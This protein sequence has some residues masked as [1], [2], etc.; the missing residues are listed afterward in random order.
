MT[1]ASAGSAT[2]SLDDDE[3]SLFGLAS[4]LFRWR[5]TI[6]ALG[7]GGAALGIAVG[8]TSTRMYV[9]S[10]TFIPQGSEGVNSGLA[11][12]ASQ[13]GIRVPSTGAAWGPPVY[14][15]L[16][17]SPALLEPVALDTVVVAEEGGRRV[18]IIDLLKIKAS[19]AAERNDAAVRALRGIVKA[20]EDKKLAA[21]KLSVTTRWPSVSLALAQRMVRGVNQFNLET[22]KS[23]AAAE[24][25][26]VETQAAEA[27]RILRAAEDRL[28]SF[29]QRNR[30]YSNSSELLFEHDRLQGEVTLRQQ[31]YTTLLQNRE[32]AR[33]REVRDTPVIT[34]LEDPRLPVVGMPRGSV[35]KGVLGGFVG[36]GLGV[37]IAFMAQWLAAAR[38]A[39][40]EEA[41][42]FFELV[43][44]AT[45]RFFWG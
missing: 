27:E 24:R 3:I 35:Q 40:S 38:R 30:V 7:L 1:E 2:K 4:V 28:Q 12:A 21:V 45:P 32:E 25:Q 26:F 29:L 18:A 9:S 8:L 34:V 43:R 11:L 41:R 5:W 16:L 31:V 37:L 14:L 20:G 17:S 22:R 42:E 39:T 33:I 10:A 13:F 23:Q 15:E 36:G 6:V 44:Q 19:T